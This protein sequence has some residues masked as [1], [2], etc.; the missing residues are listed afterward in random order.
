[1]H[2]LIGDFRAAKAAAHRRRRRRALQSF[3]RGVL[4]FSLF[5]LGLHALLQPAEDADKLDAVLVI[6]DIQSQRDPTLSAS[7]ES[8]DAARD[9]LFL[10]V[11][12]MGQSSAK[13]A[14][15][16]FQ[17]AAAEGEF[18]G[19]LFFISDK[20][21]ANSVH[22]MT[23]L[24][25]TPED[26]AFLRAN[27]ER[28]A[29]A[30]GAPLDD[31]RSSPP[32]WPPRIESKMKYDQASGD[33]DP[34]QDADTAQAALENYSNLTIIPEGERAPGVQE[35]VIKAM[36]SRSVRDALADSTLPPEEVAAAADAVARL[37]NT[38][39]VQQGDVL[40]FRVAD[41]EKG[42]RRRR[43]VQI[44]VYKADGPVGAVSIGDDGTFARS[45]DPWKNAS[46]AQ[47]AR[48]DAF[49]ANGRTTFRLI[50][51]VYSA[52][53]RNNVPANVIGEA[54][55]HM[56]RVYDL[57]SFIDA[58]DRFTLLYANAPRDAAHDQGYVLFIGVSRRDA[59]FPCY[60]L[61]PEL[62]ADFAC[63]NEGRV[64]ASGAGS[65]AF[66]M[67]VSGSI[68]SGFGMRV[69]PITGVVRM[70]SGV[71]LAAP[72]GTPVYAA[73][74]GVVDGATSGGGYGNV[75]RLAHAGSRES[76]YAHLQSIRA[77]LAQGQAIRAGE[78]IGYV[79]STGFS[80]GPHLHFELIVDG[81]AVDPMQQIKGSSVAANEVDKLVQR[82]IQ[83]ESGGSVRAKNPR[84]SAAGLGQFIDSTWMAMMRAYRPDLTQSLSADR[85][86][87]LKFDPSLATL[88]VRKYAAE[89]E[90]VL[91]RAGFKA[92]AGQ[93]YL[94]HFLGSGGALAALSAPPLA[95]ISSVLDAGVTTANPFLEG[96]T[97]AWLIAWADKKMDGPASYVANAIRTVAS[98]RFQSYREALDKILQ[99]VT[100]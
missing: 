23:S 44:G 92:T 35:F 52:A 37:L 5:G 25:A 8:L 72:V 93:L 26:F 43:A 62:D 89:N 48:G 6:P 96:R 21:L 90:A 24:P 78:L 3:F 10:S 77:G 74:S 7:A 40:A 31:R 33:G 76:V 87:A 45:E 91:R 1:M 47:L 30:P 36:A 66:A 19:P 29:S 99:R 28:D 88:M 9:P 63:M 58:E 82:I 12:Q 80:T 46:L 61:R 54:I 49:D 60:V 15:I 65:G 69:H 50:D 11:P 95:A 2:R 85:I 59:E 14:E 79:G 68:S 39:L 94:A 57:S 86:L 4:L 70:H 53:V 73:F 34:A 56:A 18:N 16:R 67:P 32:S 41:A 38:Q 100:G 83:V 84:S 51:G 42:A 98:M 13:R 20:L 27:G 81:R 64:E 75:V 71:D 55:M 22:L 97:V 17:R